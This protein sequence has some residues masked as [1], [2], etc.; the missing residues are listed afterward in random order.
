ARRGPVAHPPPRTPPPPPAAMGRALSTCCA[1]R[2]PPTPKHRERTNDMRTISVRGIADAKA[3]ASVAWDLV[4]DAVHW[5]T[6][7]PNDEASLEREGAP[8][9]DGLGA[10][11]VFRTGRYV[12]REEV[13]GFD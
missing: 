1:P 3:P 2:P 12:L 11:R 13:V 7:A 4:A 5:P 8:T 10:I 6:W 9:R